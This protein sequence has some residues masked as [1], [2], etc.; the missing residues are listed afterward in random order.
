M[1]NGWENSGFAD[2]S[3]KY[4][5]VAPSSVGTGVYYC[6]INDFYFFI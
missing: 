4:S 5:F 1:T 3:A 2:G 6:S